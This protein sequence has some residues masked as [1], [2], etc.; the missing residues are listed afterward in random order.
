MTPKPSIELLSDIT[1]HEIPGIRVLGILG[2]TSDGVKDDLMGKV[3]PD[4]SD[5]LQIIRP[6]GVDIVLCGLSGN[7]G[8]GTRCVLHDNQASLPD[9]EKTADVFALK[10]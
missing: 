10:A 4:P 3:S 5:Q 9:T 7:S 8:N 2:T 6:G 1:K